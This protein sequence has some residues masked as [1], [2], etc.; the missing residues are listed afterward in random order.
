[1]KSYRITVD[2]E[3][4]ITAFNAS[5]AQDAI[6]EALAELDALGSTVTK[7]AIDHVEELG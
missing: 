4:E 7:L 2:F 1:M 5:D 6:E 3:V